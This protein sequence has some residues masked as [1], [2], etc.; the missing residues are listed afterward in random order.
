MGVPI[1]GVDHLK[2][3]LFLVSLISAT[4]Y[5]VLNAATY[6]TNKDPIQKLSI[7]FAFSWALFLNPMFMM[8]IQN[9]VIDQIIWILSMVYI[10]FFPLLLLEIVFKTYAAGKKAIQNRGRNLN[11]E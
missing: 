3:I 5:G 10:V 1:P 8:I 7:L 4:A 11:D 6:N 9:I 2:L